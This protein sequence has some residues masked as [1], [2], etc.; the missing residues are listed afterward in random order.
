MTLQEGRAGVVIHGL[1]LFDI[2]RLGEK[3][4]NKF[5]AL[6]LQEIEQVDGLTSEEFQLIRKFV[7][8]GFN[9]FTRSLL[10]ALLGDV[11]IPPY[12]P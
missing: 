1:D 9:E 10:R 7:L 12:V 3:K 2:F 11:E 6:T 4:K 5:I 8:D